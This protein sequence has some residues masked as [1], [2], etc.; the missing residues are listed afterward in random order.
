MSEAQKLAVVVD[1]NR[2][3]QNINKENALAL[4]KIGVAVFPSSGKVPLIPLYNR[5]DTEITPED[6][7]AA[8][9]KYRDEHDVTPVHVG[10]TKNS[11]VVKRMFRAFRDAVPS[12]ATGPSGLVVIDADAKDEGPTKMAALFEENG[13]IPEGAIA[14]PTKSGGKHFIFADP[15]RIFSN[16]AGLLKKNYGTDVRGAGGQIVAPGSM[17]DD[18]R[19][20][21]TRDDLV[22]FLR[23]FLN[24]S[25]PALPEYVVSLIGAASDGNDEVVPSKEREVVEALRAADLSEH[26]SDFDPAIGKYDLDALKAENVE[27]RALY[28]NPSE[29]CS[30]NRFLAARHVM[31]EWPDMPAPALSIFFSQWEG[32]GSY[33]DEKPKSGEY[34]DRQIAR[35]WLKNQGLSK[36]STG[37]AFGAVVDET[38]E[39]AS[40][41]SRSYVRDGYVVANYKPMRWLVKRLIPLNSVGALYGLPNVG[42]SFVV[43][44]LASHVSRGRDWFGRKAKSGDVL[45]LYA[46]GAEGIAARAKAWTDNNDASGPGV[47]L[48]NGVPNLFSD[49]T[50]AKKIVAAARECEKESGQPVRLII[51]DTLAAATAGADGSSDRDMGLVCDRLRKVANDLDCAVLIVHHSGKDVSKGMRGSSAILGAVDFSLLAE[52][53]NGASSISVEKM[54]DARKGQTFK[55]K[56]V[57]VVIGVDEDG[58]NVT[59]CI[60]RPVEAGGA[61]S[62]IDLGDDEPVPIPRRSDTREDRVAMLIEVARDAA[63]KA[64][65]H[66]EPLDEVALDAKTLGAALNA[67]RADFCAL[68]GKALTEI[69]NKGVWRVIETAADA[70]RLRVQKP[71]IYVVPE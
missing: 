30:T 13:G 69:N 8:I 19:S 6:R 27:F 31:R 17:L 70:G 35:E 22:R 42:K 38:D 50:A 71:R 61:L 44:D 21:G 9:E 51:V 63:I 34:D 47:A 62:A 66:E 28:D 65:A 37:E 64:A 67:R 46:E 7:D 3:R 41:S 2:S 33:T 60:V 53:N 20:Y 39:G 29:D 43:F 48:M 45:Y 16:R 54:R 32:A 25:L 49:K 36:P 55:F 57:E 40:P 5:L 56:L 14:S 52:E 68:D 18:G 23:A 24:N 11:E 26:E 1:N 4:A 10:A 59:S 58:E 15:E 12:I